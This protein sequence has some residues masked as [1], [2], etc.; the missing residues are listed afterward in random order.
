MDGSFLGR[1]WKFPVR[2]DPGTGKILMSEHE[3]D[4]HESIRIILHTAKGERMMRPD[5]GCGVHDYVF[6]SPDSTTMRLMET[7]IIEAIQKW[8]PR[9]HEVQVTIKMDEYEPAKLRI[10]VQYVVRTT[11]NL[12]NQVYPFYL[13]EGSK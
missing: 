1:G 5:F 2:V 6:A 10:N 13:Y 7:S 4:I 12:F 3:E 8:E 11:N 9:V